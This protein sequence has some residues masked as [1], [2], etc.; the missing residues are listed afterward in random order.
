VDGVNGADQNDA[1]FVY[2][3]IVVYD[4]KESIVPGSGTLAD[5]VPDNSLL[6]DNGQGAVTAQTVLDTI[7]E[8][9]AEL[10]VD[11]ANGVDQN[12]ALFIYRKI[13]VYNFKESIVPGSGSLSDIVPDD[14]LL[15]DGV[16]AEQVKANIEAIEP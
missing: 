3:K 1:L 11:G 14:G 12:D 5:I 10:D 15:P 7:N 6:P 2:R 13:V 4:F 16:T 9:G 8:L